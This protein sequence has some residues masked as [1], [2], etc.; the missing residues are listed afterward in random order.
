MTQYVK[1]TLKEFEKMRDAVKSSLIQ[2]GCWDN[3]DQKVE[4]DKAA[5]AA[6]AIETRNNI[7]SNF[8]WNGFGH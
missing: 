1:V 5:K 8:N 3:E 4:I 2:S 6:A 7:E